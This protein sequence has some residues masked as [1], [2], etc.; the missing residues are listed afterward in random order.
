[1]VHVIDGIL[2]KSLG[3]NEKLLKTIKFRAVTNN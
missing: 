1:M 3:I 2:K